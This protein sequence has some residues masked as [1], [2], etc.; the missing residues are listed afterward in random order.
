MQIDDDFSK[1]T[2][3]SKSEIW[4]VCLDSMTNRDLRADPIAQTRIDQ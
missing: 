3:L 2:T 1:I 4:K